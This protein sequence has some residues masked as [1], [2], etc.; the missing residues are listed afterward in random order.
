M[1]AAT[2]ACRKTP[3]ATP[4]SRPHDVGAPR[5]GNAKPRTA[6]APPATPL[7]K[8]AFVRSQA[9]SLGAQAIIE[10]AARLG[11]T[12]S[13][14]YIHKVRSLARA[15]SNK[16]TTPAAGKAG[17]ASRAADATLRSPE[18]SV[19]PDFL[20]IAIEIGLTR[21]RQLINDVERTLVH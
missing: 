17:T 8:A 13:A 19:E 2:S 1:K 14:S 20:K 10:A 15:A 16:R 21:A 3:T 18:A 9:Q 4:H 5:P 6:A 12:M 11:L 7:S